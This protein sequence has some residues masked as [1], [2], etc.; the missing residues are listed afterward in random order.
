MV[1]DSGDSDSDDDEEV[2]TNSRLR[3]SPFNYNKEWKKSKATK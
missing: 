3:P 1:D 2:I